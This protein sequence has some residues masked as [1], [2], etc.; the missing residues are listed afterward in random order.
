MRKERASQGTGPRTTDV[1]M[2]TTPVAAPVAAVPSELSARDS[3]ALHDQAP[4]QS[5]SISSPSAV[6]SAELDGSTHGHGHK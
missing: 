2:S 5:H 1:P 3:E 4:S 6:T